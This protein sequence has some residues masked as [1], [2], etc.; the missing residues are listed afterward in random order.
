MSAF[1]VADPNVTP[2]LAAD[3]QPVT[4]IRGTDAIGHGALVVAA[5]GIDV[6]G[7]Y[8]WPPDAPAEV[9]FAFS[10][11]ILSSSTC[12]VHVDWPGLLPTVIGPVQ[13]GYIML[14]L[15][16][17]PQFL[18]FLPDGGNVG[19]T[20]VGPFGQPEIVTALQ[21]GVGGPEG[22]YSQ[23]LNFQYDQG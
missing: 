22:K 8:Q 23:M 13:A 16:A 14:L 2:T 20:F 15:E 12:N 21:V 3:S 19:A 10:F 6:T 5:G 1:Q 7:S 18:I 9:R 17:R 11:E 4:V